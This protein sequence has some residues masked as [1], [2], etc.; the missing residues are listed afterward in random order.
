M[1]VVCCGA[2]QC[3]WL[4]PSLPLLL[5]KYCLLCFFLLQDAKNSLMARILSEKTRKSSEV[6]Y[7]MK[8]PDVSSE[9]KL[10]RSDND[11]YVSSY[12]FIKSSIFI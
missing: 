6:R 10:H 12:V 8:T 3:A 7:L 1:C 11:L 4:V 9:V 2:E 5:L